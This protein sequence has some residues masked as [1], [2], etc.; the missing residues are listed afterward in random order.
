MQIFN[1]TRIGYLITA[2]LLSSAA[3]YAQNPSS[4]TP[5][6]LEIEK[7]RL[8][9]GSGDAEERRDALT[10]L[11]AMH[12][13]D[14]SRVAVTALTDPMPIVRVTAI[15]AIVS[16]PANESAAS[17]LPLLADKDEFVRRETAYA[18]GR[19]KSRSAISQLSEL[20]LT[21][22]E[23]G[24]RGAAA[25]ALGDIGDAT[26]VVALSNVLNPQSQMTV[27]KKKKSRREQNPFVLRSAARALGQ[28]GDR[29]G[30]PALMIVL[31]DETAEDDLR[32]ESARALGRT[33]DPGAL[34][35]LRAAM[36]ASD[37]YLA[38]AA[39]EAVRLIVSQSH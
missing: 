19:T 33:R 10:R 30:T 24:V 9:L 14:A 16:L 36:S 12:H 35:A 18:I 4:L 6:Q 13:P 7:Q 15:A 17:L 27:K 2:L 32:R 22:K 26:A 1:F 39:A 23:D 3:V 5:R 34:S 29:A 37:P 21:D 28:I 8:R 38:Q 11:G 31:Q 25:V 20:L